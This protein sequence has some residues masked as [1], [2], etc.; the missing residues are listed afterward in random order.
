MTFGQRL[1]E[2]R[3]AK[4]LSQRE[5]ADRAGIDF[6]YLSKLENDRMAPPSARTIRVLAEL[7]DADTDELSVLAGKIPEDLVDVLSRN[8][9][10][11]KLFRSLAGDL[12]TRDDWKGFLREKSGDDPGAS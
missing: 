9:D 8:P 1:R 2:L 6:S 4:N 11:V 12:N 3:K 7:L 5:L 10:A